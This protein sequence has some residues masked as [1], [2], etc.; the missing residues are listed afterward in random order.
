MEQKE[1]TGQ[2]LIF[3]FVFKTS[4]RLQKQNLQLEKNSTDREASR[5]EAEVKRLIACLRIYRSRKITVHPIN[6]YVNMC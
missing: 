3:Y 1:G 2:T 6:L 5:Q 4:S